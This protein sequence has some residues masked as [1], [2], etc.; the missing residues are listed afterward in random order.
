MDHKERESERK[1]LTTL[2][3]RN[4]R[5]RVKSYLSIFNNL[6]KYKTD[7]GEETTTGRSQSSDNATTAMASRSHSTM[8]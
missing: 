3:L 6:L 1:Q 4:M 2:E 5:V 7:T 8:M